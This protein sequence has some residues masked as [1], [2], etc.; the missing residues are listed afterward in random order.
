MFTSSITRRQLGAKL[1]LITLLKMSQMRMT[2]LLFRKSIF[3]VFIG[4]FYGFNRPWHFWSNRSFWD[5]DRF[6]QTLFSGRIAKG[7]TCQSHTG[8]QWLWGRKG[9]VGHCVV[10]GSLARCVNNDVNWCHN[11]DYVQ[12]INVMENYHDYI[13]SHLNPLRAKNGHIVNQKLTT[14]CV[15]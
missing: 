3:T 8:R 15:L 2:S 11:L 5:G 1:Y 4:R 12:N 13:N 14:F 6:R 7:Q 9:A 10:L